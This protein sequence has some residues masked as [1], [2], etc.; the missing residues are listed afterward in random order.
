MSPHD[1]AVLFA[2]NALGTFVFTPLAVWRIT[3]NLKRKLLMAIA[4]AAASIE[5]AATALTTAATELT[6]SAA[7]IATAIQNAG[8]TT[9]LDQPLVDL[10]TAVTAVTAAAA[11]VK[12]AAGA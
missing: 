4:D 12:T 8:N 7:A 9:A 1:A 5:N 10:G 6:T 2:G 11:A 3:V